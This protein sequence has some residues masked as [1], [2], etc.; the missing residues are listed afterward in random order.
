[1]LECLRALD[2]Q[3]V[4]FVVPVSAWRSNFGHLQTLRLQLLMSSLRPLY[5]VATFVFICAKRTFGKALKWSGQDLGEKC[6]PMMAE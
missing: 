1:M 4:I 3:T 5:L 2:A 6:I